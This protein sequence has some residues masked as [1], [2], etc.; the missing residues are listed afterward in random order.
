VY[1]V[2]A[3][4]SADRSVAQAALDTA[5]IGHGIHYP[6]PV[7]LQ[8]AFDGYGKGRGSLPV[9]EAIADEFLSLPMFPGLDVEA[10][11][12]IASVVFES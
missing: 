5:G 7:H 3:V 4:R 6:V 12:T 1:H 9:S 10:L 8:P 2:Y 11:T